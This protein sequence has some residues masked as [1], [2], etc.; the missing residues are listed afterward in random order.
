MLT[1]LLVAVTAVWGL[2]FTTVK[3]AVA[4]YGLLAFLAIRFAIAS[5]AL[6]ASSIRRLNRHTLKTGVG[7]GLVLTASYFCQT[8]GLKYTTPTN[9]GLITGLFVV[10]VPVADRVLFGVRPGRIFLVTVAGCLAGTVLLTGG[11]LST[12][13][14]GDLLTLACAAGY[15]L[16]ISLLSR[17]S[18]RHDAGALALVQVLVAAVVFGAAWPIFE[19]L[20]WPSAN[21]WWALLLTGLLASAGAFYIQTYVQQR[22][23]AVRTAVI[24]TMEPVFAAIFGFLLAGDRLGPIQIAGA[25]LIVAAMGTGEIYAAIRKRQLPIPGTARSKPAGGMV[26]SARSGGEDDD[27]SP[28]RDDRSG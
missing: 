14:V 28:A 10:F 5:A 7:I 3:N 4:E 23:A 26:K 1:V 13:T 20:R 27:T 21:V 8:L 17:Y 16:H 9:S 19:P 25:V 6:S 2:T 15:G 18:S 12:L 11:Q 24:L 22:L